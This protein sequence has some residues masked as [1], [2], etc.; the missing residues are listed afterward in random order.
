[1]RGPG[2]RIAKGESMTTVA[3]EPNWDLIPASVRQQIQK[4][5]LAP[6]AEAAE[7]VEEVPTAG[8]P[9]ETA[10][11][12]QVQAVEPEPVATEPAKPQTFKDVATADMTKEERYRMLEGMQRGIGRDLS[13]ATRE[14][15]ALQ[16]ENLALKR[17]LA[18]P[19]AAPI[20]PAASQGDAAADDFTGFK[21]SIGEANVKDMVRFLRSQGFVVNQD[22]SKIQ[23]QVGAVAN[24]FVVSAQDQFIKDLNSLTE[25]KWTELNEDPGFVA[26]MA[27]EDGRSGRTR[28]QNAQEK[29]DSMNATALAGYFVDY[30]S[31]GPEKQT[32]S[33][34]PSAKLDKKKFAAPNATA[35]AAPQLDEGPAKVKISEFQK[36]ADDVR[37]GKYESGDPA[38]YKTL[39]EK[40]FAEKAR[41][42]NAQRLGHIIPG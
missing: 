4:E 10:E 33:R 28:S 17:Q 2:N 8:E 40:M 20:V 15:Q 31:M 21:E 9:Q 23:E 36:F 37:N 11:P 35:S 13:K 42:D 25:N 32:A 19:A 38:V 24:S 26:Y 22:L 34:A 3:T 30:M 16:E 27:E 29:F 6:T 14:L 1:M 5:V 18:A 12:A 41:L 7:P 39:Q